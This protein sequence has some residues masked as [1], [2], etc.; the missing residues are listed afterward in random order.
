MQIINEIS[1]AQ[2]IQIRLR[3]LGSGFKEGAQ[4]T[5][6]NEPLHFVISTDDENV[7]KLA[8]EKVRIHVDN[9]RNNFR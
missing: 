6:L 8:K 3:G 7:L 4:Q 9:V 2:F 1:S 5:E